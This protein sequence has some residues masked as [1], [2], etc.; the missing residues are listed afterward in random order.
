MA[1][2]CTY[3]FSIVLTDGGVL[4]VGGAVVSE[5]AHV[6][7]DNDEQMLAILMSSARSVIESRGC[8]A[9]G[10]RGGNAR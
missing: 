9:G 7:R 2:N 1:C 5:V 8:S 10:Q 3:N 6:A 4:L